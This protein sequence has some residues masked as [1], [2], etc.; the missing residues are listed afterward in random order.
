MYSTDDTESLSVAKGTQVRNGKFS[1]FTLQNSWYE[2]GSF[3]QNNTKKQDV[4]EERSEKLSYVKLL[5]RE[6]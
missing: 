5:D 4:F 2:M 6:L 3:Q 1:E